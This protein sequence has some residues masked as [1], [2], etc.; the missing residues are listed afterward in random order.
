MLANKRMRLFG[1]YLD[2]KTHTQQPRTITELTIDTK[3]TVVLVN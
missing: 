1:P 3:S 2:S